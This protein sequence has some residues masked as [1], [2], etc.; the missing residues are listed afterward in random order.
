VI[1]WTLRDL[2]HAGVRGQLDAVVGGAVALLTAASW[3]QGDPSPFTTL[4]RGARWI[5]VDISN[6]LTTAD[7]WLNADHRRGVLIGACAVVFV[8][9]LVAEAHRLARDGSWRGAVY[10]PWLENTEREARVPEQGSLYRGNGV[11]I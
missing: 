10:R 11:S 7:A 2:A 5:G 9:A 8:T 3:Y 1:G 6:A 4:D